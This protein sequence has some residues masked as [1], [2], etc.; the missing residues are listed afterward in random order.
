MQKGI[1]VTHF[2]LVHRYTLSV[3]LLPQKWNKS[4][5][6]PIPDFLETKK[7]KTGED[8]AALNAGTRVLLYKLYKKA[9][10]SE[11][12]VRDVPHA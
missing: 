12:I 9:N 3:Y 2:W 8:K 4:K 7:K 1:S 11:F 10:G 6:Y 5:L